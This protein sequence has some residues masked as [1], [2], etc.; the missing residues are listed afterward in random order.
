MKKIQG[1]YK[2]T[3]NQKISGSYYHLKIAAP[4][5]GRGVLPGQFVHVRVNDGLE[6]FFRR[7]FSV[8]RGG[9]SLEILYDVVGPATKQ[10]AAKR[11]GETLDVIGPLGHAFT[12]PDKNIRVVV[13][14]AGGVGIAPFLTLTDK[15]RL[16]K[17]DKILLYGGRTKANIVSLK[18]FR[19]NGCRI[20]VATDDGSAGVKGRV[21]GLFS[22]IPLDP[23]T[24]LIYACGPRPMLAAIQSFAA[25]HGM[26]GELSYE[27]VMACG[28]GA[29]L[30][31]AVQTRK[32]YKTVCHDGP[33]FPLE[34][35]VF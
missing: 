28:L 5:I 32:G 31:C 4:D 11:P 6:P 27:E 13:L 25:Q 29:C 15:I 20:H 33:V 17:L 21:S 16:K 10:L 18:A 8:F 30:G 12:L 26:R 24:T 14:I 23:S 19:D 35:V 34:E 1:V 7:P 22:K 9:K 2:I 3:A